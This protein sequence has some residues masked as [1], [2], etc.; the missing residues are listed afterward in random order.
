[1]NYKLRTVIKHLQ[2]N[3]STKKNLKPYAGKL[4]RKIYFLFYP[5]INA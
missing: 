3:K 1:M 5:G 2:I 4:F